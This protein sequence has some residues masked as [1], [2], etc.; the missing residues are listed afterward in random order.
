M[1]LARKTITHL[2]S[3]S[4]LIKLTPKPYK[5]ISAYLTNV[6]GLPFCGR[7]ASLAYAFLFPVPLHQLTDRRFLL[8]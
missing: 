4:F 2:L 6:L 1:E 7:V 8:V 3:G 5:E